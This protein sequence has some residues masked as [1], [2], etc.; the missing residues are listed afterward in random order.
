MTS[1]SEH[2]DDQ[3]ASRVSEVTPGRCTRALPLTFVTVDPQPREELAE[4]I[5]GSPFT[6]TLGN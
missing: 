3:R 6:G 1:P 2:E 4:Q 5:P